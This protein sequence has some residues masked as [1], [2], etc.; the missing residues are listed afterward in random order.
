MLMMMMMM[1]IMFMIMAMAVTM[2][3]V[4]LFSILLPGMLFLKVPEDLYSRMG[5]EDI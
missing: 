2:I 1:M 4:L 5:W 3:I